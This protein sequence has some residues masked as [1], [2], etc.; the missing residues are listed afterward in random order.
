MNVYDICLS[1]SISCFVFCRLR[2]P[3]IFRDVTALGLVFQNAINCQAM[4]S[5]AAR[6]QTDAVNGCLATRYYASTRGGRKTRMKRASDVRQETHFCDERACNITSAIRRQSVSINA[7]Q[8]G[9]SAAL[10]SV[11]TTAACRAAV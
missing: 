9:P 3:S 6:A 11:S 2:F 10:Y 4:K 8:T 5:V 1:R 7:T